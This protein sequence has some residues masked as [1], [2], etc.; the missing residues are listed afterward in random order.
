MGAKKENLPMEPDYITDIIDTG[1]A[2]IA[3]GD[4]DE[5][6]RQMMETGLTTFF[7]ALDYASQNQKI[8]EEAFTKLSRD[9]HQSVVSNDALTQTTIDNAAANSEMIRQIIQKKMIE[10]GTLS[11]EEFKLLYLELRH[12]HDEMKETRREAQEEREWMLRLEQEEAEKTRD[13]SGIFEVI[14]GFL[15][16]LLLGWGGKSLYDHFTKK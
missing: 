12:Y 5:F 15:G 10:D 16:G 1:S 8:R 14:G 6:T 9:V 13:N 11:P 7:K 3:V 2:E 4:I